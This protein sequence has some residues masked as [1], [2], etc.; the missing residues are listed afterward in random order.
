MIVANRVPPHPPPVGT[1][2]STTAPGD[3]P[4][5]DNDVECLVRTN[6]TTVARD[7]HPATTAPGDVP[8]MNN[9]VECL[10]RTNVLNKQGGRT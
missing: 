6:G 4:A 8:A 10:I 9:D 5:T 2:H 1:R 7:P 3:V